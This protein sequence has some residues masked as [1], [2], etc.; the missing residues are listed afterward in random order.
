MH[1]SLFVTYEIISM[2]RV[3]RPFGEVPSNPRGDLPQ[4]SCSA[5]P[6]DLWSDVLRCVYADCLMLENTQLHLPNLDGLLCDA[7]H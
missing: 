3:G 2:Q 1:S 6:R 5:L 4:T 7:G